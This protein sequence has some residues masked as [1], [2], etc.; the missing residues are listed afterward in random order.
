MYNM[1]REIL[2]DAHAIRWD[3][4]EAVPEAIATAWVEDHRGCRGN[5]VAARLPY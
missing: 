5:K 3:W 1:R 2:R 4:A